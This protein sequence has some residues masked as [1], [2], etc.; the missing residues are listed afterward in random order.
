MD[1]K[2]LEKIMMSFINGLT[3]E[4]GL[5]RREVSDALEAL[6]EYYRIRY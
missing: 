3:N 2:L 5:T 1:R 6:A 4:F